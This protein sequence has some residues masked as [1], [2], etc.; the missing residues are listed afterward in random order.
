MYGNFIEP[1]RGKV[2]KIIFKDKIDSTNNYGKENIDLIEDKS[3]I[4]AAFQ[5]SGRGRMD[6]KWLSFASDNLYASIVLKPEGDFSK[7][8]V[9][10]LTQLLSVVI[11]DVLRF[12][13]IQA[14]IKWPNDV[15][16]TKSEDDIFGTKICGILAEAATSSSKIKG[17]VLGFGLNVNATKE[18]LSKIDRP[19]TSM[20]NETGSLYDSKEIL[21][22][23]YETFFSRYDDFMEKGFNLIKDEYLS[24]IKFMGREI[25]VNMPQGSVTGIAQEITDEGAVLLNKENDLKTIT[26]GEIL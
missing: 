8:P 16:I 17:I 21:N 25:T 14:N 26:I 22:N 23:I 2:L 3:V 20:L 18:E 4:Y 7:L 15:I 9:S 11:V 10:N 5:T 24:K 6:R 13:G 1:Y 12:Y 19:A